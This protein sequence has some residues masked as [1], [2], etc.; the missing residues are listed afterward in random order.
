[1]LRLFS[2][3]TDQQ[4]DELECPAGLG[5]RKPCLKQAKK[6]NEKKKQR[7][8]AGNVMIMALHVGDLLQS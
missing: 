3:L 4:Q 8:L 7:K 1:M 5:Y 2:K 6:E